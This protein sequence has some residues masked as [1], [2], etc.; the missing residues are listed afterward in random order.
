MKRMWA[1]LALG[2]RFALASGRRARLR[3]ALTAVGVGLGVVLLLGATSV[4][5]LVDGHRDRARA[6][7]SLR[8]ESIP[9]QAG[10]R[11][12]LVASTITQFRGDTISGLLVSPE[13]AQPPVPAGLQELPG[14]GEMVVSP[15][16]AELLDSP[17]GQ[18]LL[19]D[20][21]PYERAGTI[22]AEGLRGP[23]ELYFYAGSDVLEQGGVTRR[24]DAFGSQMPP[25]PLDA[26]L[27]LVV[28]V[29]VAVL[30]LP[31]AL[32]LA[33]A[34]RF[35]GE[36]RDRRLAALRLVGADAWMARR[37]AAGEAML[38]AAVGIA[39]GVGLFLALRPAAEHLAPFD[40]GVYAKDMRPG[41]VLMVCVLLLIPAI[42]VG[43]SLLALRSVTIDPLGVVRRAPPRRRRL[44]WRL[45][46]PA[47]GGALLVPLL[48]VDIAAG[49]SFSALQVAGG[50]TMLM[51]GIAA[52]LPW[53]VET[54]VRRLGGGG[55]AWQLAVRRLQLDSGTSAR[56]VSGIA[57]AVAGAITL[58]TLFAGVDDRFV[59]TSGVEA[60]TML[61]S[62]DVTNPDAR[63]ETL[64][65]R[66]RQI[67]GVSEVF[68]TASY[69]LRTERG[70]KR[71]LHV[72]SC[73]SIE[74]LIAAAGCREGDAYIADASRARARPGEAVRVDGGGT[75]TIPPGARTVSLRKR[76]SGY[77][78]TGVL[79]TPAAVAEL[80]LPTRRLSAN[81]VYDPGRPDTVEQIRTVAALAGPVVY[82][83]DLAG[84][85][86]DDDFAAVQR[87]LFV[88]AVAVLLLIA[89][90]MLVSA[91]EQLHDRRR[92]L[93]ALVAFGTPPRTIGRSV[94]LQTAVPVALGL[95]LSVVT[96]A[97]L[98]ALLLELV[99]APVRVDLPVIAGMTAAGAA[100]V[101]LVTALSLPALRRLMRPE[102]LRFE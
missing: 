85:I 63:V 38:A 89:A 34:V 1:E 72:A 4:P 79:A 40:V 84:T 15:G 86:V 71:E 95:G 43:V 64:E 48:G 60:G 102:G 19:A 18:R 78:A 81:A 30:L 22:A 66:L 8:F 25:E 98:G 3:T 61:V 97:A 99:N 2:A 20:R 90:S 42:A 76:F 52:L 32:F 87:G 13:G 56:V 53:L 82:V 29:V 70:L 23:R 88:G 93:A 26:V 12:L 55:V 62:S 69:R 28:A 46:L 17:D 101:P 49:E 6:R 10:P 57:V 44:W 47:A 83:N 73:H 65:T 58:Q 14:P 11:T 94:L 31:V 92:L 96:G 16:L 36:Q 45:L 68:A 91:L 77:L 75:W 37:I 80:A 50:V 7:D 21:F 9:K 100:V 67:G 33:A 54:V 39:V 27:V 35:G 5:T 41:A 24:I 51:V 59:A 74:T